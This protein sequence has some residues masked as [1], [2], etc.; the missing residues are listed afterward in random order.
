MRELC[1]LD[2]LRE[3]MEQM[4][5]GGRVPVRGRR[6][7]E[8]HDDRLGWIGYCW[9]KPVFVAV[10]RPQRHTYGILQ[11]TGEFTV[12]VPAAGTMRAELAFAG[13]KSG[14]D[15]DKF[16]GH[17]LTAAPA[18]KV[19]APVVA[20][21][22]LHLECRTL[23]VQ[24]MTADRMA[25]SVLEESYPPARPARDVLRGNRRCYPRRRLKPRYKARLPAAILAA[26]EVGT[27]G[28]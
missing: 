4:T 26:V 8:R 20:E 18:R 9:G 1:D 27:D 3:V 15:V 23:L 16:Q 10:V 6:A 24:D 2:A 22:P 13:T 28:R 19:G 21:C 11:K 12:S 7:A 14:R 25:E 17:G 5:R